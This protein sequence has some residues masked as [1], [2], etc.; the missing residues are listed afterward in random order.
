MSADF[1]PPKYIQSLIGAINDAAKAA[2]TS[3][4]FLLALGLYLV[5]TVISTTD[6]DLLRGTAVQVAQLGVRA[7]VAIAYALAPTIFLFLHVHTLI[8]FDMLAANLRLLTAELA[9]AVPLAADRERC[10]ALLANVEFVQFM[11]APRGSSFRSPL[12]RFMAWLIVS[13]LPVGVFL[14]VQISFLRYQSEAIT[15]LHQVCLALALAALSWFHKRLWLAGRRRRLISTA[16][17]QRGMVLNVVVPLQ[18]IPFFTLVY[19]G[20]PGAERTTVGAGPVTE[21]QRYIAETYEGRGLLAGAWAA[22][23]AAV[24]QPLDLVACPWLGFGCR[25]LRLDHR[26]LL[27][28]TPPADVLVRLRTGTSED[29]SADLAHVEGLF[30]RGRTLRFADFSESRLYTADLMEADL[31]GASLESA[32]LRGANLYRTHLQD[33]KLQNAQLQAARLWEA[34]LQGADLSGIKL[35]GADLSTAELQGADLSSAQLRG[36][37]LS[38]AQLQGADLRGAKLEGANL[39]SAELQGANL[40]SAEL[41]GAGL[42]MAQLQG[43]FLY[44]ARLQ[45]AALVNAHLEGADLRSAQLQ[46]TYLGAASLQGADL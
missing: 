35:Q 27:A 21:V 8:R 17:F 23:N 7:P 39:S 44:D 1:E 15:A 12:F 41:Q 36:A 42:V 30:L 2:Q 16:T 11:A 20:V 33:A 31:R 28:N 9:R 4:L 18:F 25:F 32:Q 6:E 22:L 34:G 19:A 5:A 40:S 46:G 26:T 45:R 3:A 29:L 10:R 14:A 38:S 13:A 37:V 24:S 43:A